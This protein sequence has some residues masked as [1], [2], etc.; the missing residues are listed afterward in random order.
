MGTSGYC[1]TKIRAKSLHLDSLLGAMSLASMVDDTSKT[2]ITL[3]SLPSALILPWT[4]NNK[5]PMI[6]IILFIACFFIE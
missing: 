4:A 5:I 3:R 2:N 6:A 1:S